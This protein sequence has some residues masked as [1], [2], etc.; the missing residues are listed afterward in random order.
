MVWCCW[1]S[2]GT[3]GTQTG[4]QMG[5]KLCRAARHTCSIH[6]Q[7]HTYRALLCHLNTQPACLPACLLRT[8][9]QGHK[10]KYTNSLM[11]THIYSVVNPCHAFKYFYIHI[12]VH[13]FAVFTLCHQLYL[14]T[15][16]MQN[17]TIVFSDIVILLHFYKI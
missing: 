12:F 2:V 15:Y 4:A 11:R 14:Y 13:V 10:H 7:T 3:G 9:L 17:L 1:Q 8:I 6:T 16:I 5:N